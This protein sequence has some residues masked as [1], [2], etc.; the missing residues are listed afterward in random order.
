MLNRRTIISTI[1]GMTTTPALRGKEGRAEGRNKFI[2]VVI[3]R[4]AL[5]NS[6]VKALGDSLHENG[7][8]GP[9]VAVHDEPEAI[10]IIDLSNL[11]EADL[12][13]VKR[14]CEEAGKR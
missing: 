6:A 1:F 11:P 8:C 9:I 5:S 10:R 2:M 3:R 12:A 13:E 14:L 4:D 7:F